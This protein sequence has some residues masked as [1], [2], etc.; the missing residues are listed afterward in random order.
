M[1]RVLFLLSIK[2]C[3]P[4]KRPFLSKCRKSVNG[5]AVTLRR[6]PKE[7]YDNAMICYFLGAA[8]FR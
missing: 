6:D 2:L 1:R 5:K 7:D 3:T 4:K 8:D